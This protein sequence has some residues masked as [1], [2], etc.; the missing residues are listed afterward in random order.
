MPAFQT[1]S[2]Q[3]MK[4]HRLKGTAGGAISIGASAFPAGRTAGS[5]AGGELGSSLGSG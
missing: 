3:S 5:V 1:A 2:G 4:S